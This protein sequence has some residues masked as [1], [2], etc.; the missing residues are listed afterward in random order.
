MRRV[1]RWIKKETN[2]HNKYRKLDIFG[3]RNLGIAGTGSF[4]NGIL[5]NEITGFSDSSVKTINPLLVQGGLQFPRF[6][7]NDLV[8][9]ITSG[10]VYVFI[11]S[12]GTEQK[13]TLPFAKQGTIVAIINKSANNN[14]LVNVQSGDNINMSVTSVA[15]P[16]AAWFY[17]DGDNT[18][19]QLL[20]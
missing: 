6:T 13:T 18:W 8:S 5:T 7:I 3:G 10:G 15:V 12:S 19:I 4:A 14:V 11:N 2:D 1:F 16:V 20:P 17:S 9:S